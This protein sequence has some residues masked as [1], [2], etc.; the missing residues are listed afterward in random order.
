MDSA[1]RPKAMLI[2]VAGIFYSEF[3]VAQQ[4]RYTNACKD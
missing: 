1:L 2:F 3:S 4:C